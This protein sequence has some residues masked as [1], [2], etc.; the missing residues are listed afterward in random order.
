MLTS[1][2]A[3]G[4]LSRDNHRRGVAKIV[5]ALALGGALAFASAGA[6]A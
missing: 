2:T 4:R 6:S 1:C 5:G 3:I